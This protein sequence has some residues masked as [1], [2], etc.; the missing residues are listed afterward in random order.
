MLPA[1][2]TA[3]EPQP[4]RLIGQ[5]SPGPA[6]PQLSPGPAVDDTSATIALPLSLGQSFHEKR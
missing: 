5:L 1:A 4:L 3:P 2:P 6:V